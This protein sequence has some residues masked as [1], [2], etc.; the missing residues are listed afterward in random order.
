MNS[1]DV[2]QAYSSLA[3]QYI[4]LLGSVVIVHP[5]DLLLIERHLGHLEGP[6]LDAGCGRAT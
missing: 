3:Q 5:D 2:Q 6:V 1:R 4:D